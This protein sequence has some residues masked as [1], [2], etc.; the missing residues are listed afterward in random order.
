VISPRHDGEHDHADH[1]RHQRDEGHAAHGAG[2]HAGHSH[3]VSAD[4]D[5]RLLA[6]ALAL[7]VGFMVAEVTVGLV[8]R[9]LAL[10]ADAG[11]MLTDAAA[12]AVALVA[13]RLAARPA[14]G[15]Y[16]YGL[17]RV[18]RSSRRRPTAS[19]CC[20]SPRSSPSR[21][22]VGCSTRRRSAAAWS[23]SSRWPV[24]W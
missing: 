12:I 23:W 9:S 3:G 18:S 7:I 1:D 14:R 2:G 5:R 11:H 13:M 17:K 6:T 19:P 8:A 4:A 22:S 16:T 15:S 10:V 20:C 21:A 24:S